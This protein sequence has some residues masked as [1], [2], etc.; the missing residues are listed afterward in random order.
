MDE[1]S[2]LT[3]R[4]TQAGILLALA[5]YAVTVV[6]SAWLM[7]DA[8]IT[9]RTVDNLI[10]GYGLT[11]NTVE[12]VQAYTNPL[13]LFFVSAA[14]FFTREIFYTPLYLS[15]AVSV[16]AAGLVAWRVAASPTAA[17]LGLILL[18]SSK[19]SVDYATS[20]LENPLTH[21]ATVMFAWQLCRDDAGEEKLFRLALIS[22]L[23]AINRM[24]SILLFLPA[25]GQ[26][27]WRL[28]GRQTL[29]ATLLGFVPFL[30]WELFSLFYYGFLFPNTA[31]AKLS[32]GLSRFDLIG[33][34]LNYVLDSL[35]NDPLTPLTIAVGIGWPLV[36][37]ERPQR[38]LAIG[39]VSYMVY[40]VSIGGDF[41]SGRFFSAPLVAA[42]A[43]L[44]SRDRVHTIKGTLIAAAVI[45]GVG[46]VSPNPP[47][48][49]GADYGLQGVASANGIADER[50]AYY[51]TAGLVPAW[52]SDPGVEYPD[53]PW[54]RG[55]KVFRPPEDQHG[56]AVWA[57]VG[58]TGFYAGPRLHVIDPIGLGDPLLARLPPFEVSDWAI[59]HMR[60]VI[61]EGYYETVLYGENLI[62][63][64][65]LAVYFDKLRIVTG[66]KL[67]D[68]GRLRE[69]WRV[70]TGAYDHL[71]DRQRYR[72][73]PRVYRLVS[74]AYEDPRNPSVHMALAEERLRL[75][76]TSKGMAALKTA[77]RLKNDILLKRMQ[78]QGFSRRA[79]AG[80]LTR[81]LADA[82]RRQAVLGQGR[83]PG[84]NEGETVL[85]EYEILVNYTFI[86]VSLNRARELAA[87]GD[88]T[89]AAAVRAEAVAHSEAVLALQPNASIYHLLGT[90]LRSDRL[91]ETEK[92]E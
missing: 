45:L 89:A 73:P 29:R 92:T 81:H 70:N 54:A 64:D 32:T 9:F 16:V 77:L 41:M 1:P 49:S 35:E 34:G 56:A 15:I 63:D 58:L 75:G 13:W 76:N 62:A 51:Q 42:A 50:A 31:Y 78:E 80:Y 28:P 3:E 37:R 87:A 61:P 43:L 26:V 11:W 8:F 6:R 90:A 53:H 71:I 18:A 66:G 38:A 46:L 24:D 17:L 60:R 88:S 27:A 44:V 20:G 68:W 55:A 59:G 7:D 83:S 86:Y 79:W 39:I 10:H 14:Y 65:S 57:N 69:V 2:V 12:R 25:L 91:R 84:R 19:T 48:L 5:I 40:V 82:S 22:S 21:L 52:L 47:L 72:I 85:D 23:A 36:A 4:R 74:D 33:Q 30:L 67:A